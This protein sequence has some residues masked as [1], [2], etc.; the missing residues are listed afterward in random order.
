M[1]DDSFQSKG[2]KAR[3][4]ALTDE[5]KTEI[6]RKGAAARWADRPIQ[7]S[8]K[9]S[10]KDEFGIDVDC[11][12]LN[13]ATK[14][15]VISQRGMGEAIGLSAG[16]SKLHR[17]LASKSI[18]QFVGPELAQKVSN[19]LIFQRGSGGPEQP[20]SIVHGYDVTILIEICGVI[21]EAEAAGKLNNA[22]VLKQARIIQSAAAKL[23]IRDLVYALAGYSPTTQEVISAFKMF[24]REEAR[25]YEKEFPP[26]LYDQWQRLYQIQMPERGKPWQFMH[27]TINHIYHPLAKSNGRITQLLRA[28]KSAGG[29]R[30]K[31][32][33][34]FLSDIGTRALRFQLGRVTE[35]AESSPD[36]LTYEHRFSER[37]GEQQAFNFNSQPQK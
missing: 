34:Q 10:F 30:Q 24:V 12:V 31:K 13:D 33:F 9:G 5:Q 15:A 14:T 27:L 25:K 19:P 6:A 18:A 11:Y 22:N 28:L 36:F 1:N 20:P 35:M 8:H 37:F 7:V 21:I 17:F 23:G 26:E 3:D 32:L 29:N 2:G 4:K 16:G